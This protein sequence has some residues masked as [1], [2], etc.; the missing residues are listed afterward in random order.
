MQPR[1]R[2][3]TLNTLDVIPG[4]FNV[5]AQSSDSQLEYIILACSR[6]P[7][8]SPKRRA[9]FADASA[10]PGAEKSADFST[11]LFYQQSARNFHSSVIASWNFGIPVYDYARGLFR[12]A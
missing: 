2:Q 6:T 9:L 5:G 3:T 11:E 10:A 12:E 1:P 4:E 7:S 8:N